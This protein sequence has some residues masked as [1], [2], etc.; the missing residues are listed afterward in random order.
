[1]QP[2]K[3]FRLTDVKNVADRSFSKCSQRYRCG[4]ILDIAAC[5]APCRFSRI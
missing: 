2:P 3:E 4:N 1:M 5:A